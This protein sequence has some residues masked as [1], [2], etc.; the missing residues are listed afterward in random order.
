M[1]GAYICNCPQGYTGI[2]CEN[3]TLFTVNKTSTARLTP[4]TSTGKPVKRK[5]AF[6]VHRNLNLFFLEKRPPVQS[7]I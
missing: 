6:K 3:Q 4:T 7:L 1:S 5:L 2:Q